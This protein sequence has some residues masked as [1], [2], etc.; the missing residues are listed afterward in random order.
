MEAPRTTSPHRARVQTPVG[1][2]A[3]QK[4]R[5]GFIRRAIHFVSMTAY[6][7]CREHLVSVVVLLACP[8]AIGF[9]YGTRPPAKSSPV[10]SYLHS[11]RS[12][13]TQA[14]PALRSRREP[15]LAKSVVPPFPIHSE[16]AEPLIF[17]IA[18][19]EEDAVPPLPITVDHPKPISRAN[20]GPTPLWPGHAGPKLSLT[21]SATQCVWLTGSIEPEDAMPTIIQN[22]S[23]IHD[24][25]APSRDSQ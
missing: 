12:E 3:P 9:Y 20:E 7:W 19:E 13:T 14:P 17:A 6:P 18:S 4:P 5:H 10:P 21:D 2:K 24:L 15:P 1:G 16:E 11:N 22:V 25:T 8:V 23:R